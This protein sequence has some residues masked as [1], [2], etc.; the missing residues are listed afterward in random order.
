MVDAP[1]V[2][3]A[4]TAAITA[5]TGADLA[6]VVAAAREARDVAKF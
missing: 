5:S 4:L 3:G 2:E 6:A 1:F